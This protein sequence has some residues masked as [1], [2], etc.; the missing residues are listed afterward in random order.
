MAWIAIFQGIWMF[1]SHSVHQRLTIASAIIGF[2]GVILAGFALIMA[3]A[4]YTIYSV[5][6]GGPNY[7]RVAAAKDLIG[8]VLPPPEYILEAYLEINLLFNQLGDR[9]AH[10]N[11]LAELHTQF[12]DRRAYWKASVLPDDLKAEL[13]EAAGGEAERFWSEAEAEFL[14]AIDRNDKQSVA[15]SFDRLSTIYAKH[16]S[17]IDDI[18]ELNGVVAEIASAAV[19]QATGLSEVNTA[20]NQMDEVTQ[21]NAAMVEEST[22][23]SARL[24]QEAEQMAELVA[25]FRAVSGDFMQKQARPQNHRTTQL[26]H[27]QVA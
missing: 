23:A 17:V 16:R 26:P 21:Q 27:R 19:E 6:I 8:D 20:I 5:G 24:T 15:K 4:N 1:R 22:A 10:K 25:R 3:I 14:P 18:V 13:T 11:H 9:E 2:G 7:Q 12:S